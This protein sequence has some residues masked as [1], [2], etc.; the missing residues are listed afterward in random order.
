MNHSTEYFVPNHDPILGI[1]DTNIAP[2]ITLDNWQ[3]KA[4]VIPHENDD[5]YV[6][7]VTG[8]IAKLNRKVYC[9]TGFSLKTNKPLWSHPFLSPEEAVSWISRHFQQQG[10]TEDQLATV[11]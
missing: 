11:S 3:R 9:A 10:A 6:Y 2:S 1:R 4:I 5:I 8:E 7:V